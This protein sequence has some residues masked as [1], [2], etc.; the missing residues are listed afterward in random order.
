MPRP[1]PSYT[2]PLAPHQRTMTPAEAR[3]FAASVDD[4]VSL[5]NNE[6]SAHGIA[7]SLDVTSPGITFINPDNSPPTF[8]SASE[9]GVTNPPSRR[10]PRPTRFSPSVS[11]TSS[12]YG[13]GTLRHRSALLGVQIGGY[14][15]NTTL[16]PPDQRYAP[17]DL[18]T[19]AAHSTN[20]ASR[21]AR[22]EGRA[23][24]APFNLDTEMPDNESEDEDMD[25]DDDD[26]DSEDEDDDDE[27]IYVDDGITQ[28]S[29][30]QHDFSIQPEDARI[31]QHPHSELVGISALVEPTP[32]DEWI[33]RREVYGAVEPRV[34]ARMRERERTGQVAR[35]ARNVGVGRGIRG[36]GRGR[37]S[38]IGW[39]SGR[40]RVEP[41]VPKKEWP[42][43]RKMTKEELAAYNQNAMAEDREA[44]K[45]WR[46]EKDK[47]DKEEDGKQRAV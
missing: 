39:S 3:R 33:S 29:D 30:D 32:F 36:R 34:E 20:I 37:G 19:N 14:I 6:V 5:T 40:G 28:D 12:E 8:T 1:P 16:A 9:R 26:D 13:Y 47:K 24:N 18:T 46:E 4:A 43:A 35:L 42:D 41:E 27:Q 2:N 21:H 23:P 45:K 10:G 31:L 7:G 44:N 15:E 17:R 25:E 38:I 22:I 11:P